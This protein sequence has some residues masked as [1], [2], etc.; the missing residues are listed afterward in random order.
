MMVIMAV[1]TTVATTPMLSLVSRAR[2]RYNRP[3]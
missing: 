2:V 3:A 1:V